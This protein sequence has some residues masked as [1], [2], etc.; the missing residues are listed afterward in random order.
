MLKH[1][2]KVPKIVWV[3]AAGRERQG[4]QDPNDC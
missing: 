3:C 4:E 1:T 2:N